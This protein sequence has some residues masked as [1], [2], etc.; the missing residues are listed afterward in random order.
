MTI[1]IPAINLDAVLG[2]ISD[3]I[4][5]GLWAG[6]MAQQI[7]RQHRIK[8]AQLGFYLA[9][10]AIVSTDDAATVASGKRKR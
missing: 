10:I 4:L 7:E 2:L 5:D 8:A 1:T 6:L 3:H 9:F